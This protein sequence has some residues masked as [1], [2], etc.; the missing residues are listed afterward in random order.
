MFFSCY[1][2]NFFFNLFWLH[3]NCL[4]VCISLRD[5]R[6]QCRLDSS[7]RECSN[8]S[9]WCSS[10]TPLS[11]DRCCPGKRRAREGRRTFE[12]SSAPRTSE[13]DRLF[14][15]F[16]AAWTAVWKPL[17]AGK[18]RQQAKL[19]RPFV[20]LLELLLKVFELADKWCR[21]V[22]DS[23]RW[24]DRFGARSCQLCW[25]GSCAI[26][27]NRSCSGW[28]LCM[29][30]TLSACSSCSSRRCRSSRD[31][32]LASSSTREAVQDCASARRGESEENWMTSQAFSA[33]TLSST[34][35]LF[36]CTLDLLPRLCS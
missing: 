8:R 28:A 15:A 13:W 35:C 2:Q 24:T 27:W 23:R 14:R 30:A 9:W 22:F 1:L 26:D 36:A 4:F 34:P 31:D 20:R 21:W 7:T 25:I 32:S 12:D 3:C 11:P 16:W 10:L 5:S 29:S 6:T 19:A 17:S 33:S 18:M